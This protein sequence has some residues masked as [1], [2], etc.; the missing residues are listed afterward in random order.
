[1]FDFF[2]DFNFWKSF[3]DATPDGAA[4]TVRSAR[5]ATTA[6][7]AAASVS[8]SSASATTA[9]TAQPARTPS[10]EKDATLSM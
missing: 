1:M 8:P 2:P 10:A 7:T 4:R 9:T 5:S 3:A 6:P